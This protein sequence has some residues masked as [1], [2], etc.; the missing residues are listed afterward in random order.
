[1]R[2]AKRQQMP[3]DSVGHCSWRD[4]GNTGRIP[5]RS[6]VA[7][8]TVISFLI[9]KRSKERESLRETNTMTVVVPLTAVDTKGGGA[10]TE[11]GVG[12]VVGTG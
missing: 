5:E 11:E 4:G 8:D 9:Q 1:M 7:E 12:V 3:V 2:N 10:E 6:V